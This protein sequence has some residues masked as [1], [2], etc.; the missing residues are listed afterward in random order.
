MLPITIA[1][2]HCHTP[3]QQAFFKSCFGRLSVEA[4]AFGNTGPALELMEE[5]WKR[6]AT[7]ESDEAVCWRE[8]MTSLGW[9][10]GILLI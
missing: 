9:E 1:G 6:R 8:T 7:K 3:Q 5:V 2:C 10:N 4:R